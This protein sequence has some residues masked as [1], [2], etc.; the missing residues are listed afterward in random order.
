[1]RKTSAPE[2]MASQATT[3]PTRRTPSCHFHARGS[4]VRS[5]KRIPY[6]VCWSKSVS[7]RSR[8]GASSRECF[9]PDQLVTFLSRQPGKV[10]HAEAFVVPPLLF[11]SGMDADL[12]RGP[13]QSLQGAQKGVLPSLSP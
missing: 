4:V 10:L 13:A 5:A 1:M 12:R 6:R 9:P 11:E 3:R 7:L 8:D 2:T